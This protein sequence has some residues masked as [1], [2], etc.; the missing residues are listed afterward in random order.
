MI[1]SRSIHVT[2]NGNFHYLFQLCN[3]P[4][5]VCAC[6]SMYVYRCVCDCVIHVLAVVN[7]A[8]N[9]G[10]HVSF[11][12]FVSS[13]YMLRSEIARSYSNFIFGF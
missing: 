3:I 6:V 12:V 4:F 5:Y 13:V 11:R 8:V 10:V 1:T 9:T 7:A 2:P